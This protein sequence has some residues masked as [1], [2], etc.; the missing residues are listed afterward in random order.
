MNM[1]ISLKKIA[2]FLLAVLMLLAA[3]ACS[4]EAPKKKKKKV[5]K[6][7]VIIVTEPE[8]EINNGYD[9]EDNTSDYEETPA[10]RP[11]R[12]L[13]DVAVS[14]DEY[15]E[16]V[17][18]E[19]DYDYT[20]LNLS[21]DYVIVYGL[22]TWQKRYEGKD[23][24]ANGTPIAVTHT[25]NNRV[26]ANDLAKFFKDKYNLNL[27]VVLDTDPA[28]TAATKKILVGDTAFY[29]TNLSDKNFAVKVSGDNLIFEGGHF[30][31]VEKAVKWY[32]TIEV[33][34]GKVATLTGK[35]TDFSSSVTLSNGIKYDYVWGDEHDG[36]EVI[37]SDKWSQVV[38]KSGDDL[39]NVFDDTH[40][41]AV[42]NGRLRL[43]GDR[44]YDESNPNVGWA[45]SGETDTST[46][47]LFRNGYAE[48]RARL[49]Y[50]RGAFPAI[51]TMSASTA[52]DQNVPNYE[53]DDGYGVYKN[54]VWDIEFDLFESFADHDHM[55]T[56]V[57]KWYTKIEDYKDNG[58][59][60]QT[61]KIWLDWGDGTKFDVFDSLKLPNYNLGSS[62]YTIAYS[63]ASDDKYNWT[64]YFE[65]IDTLNNE[66]H[67]YGYLY[68]SDHVEVYVDGEMFLEFDWNPA[69]DYKNN[70]DVSKN[71]NGVGFNLWHYFIYDMMLYT[72]QKYPDR[73][74]DGTG[75]TIEDV[76]VSM[77]VDYVRLYQD[78]DD[79]S[80]ALCYPAAQQ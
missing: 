37:D 45:M 59:G 61:A 29:K 52:F 69:Y 26:A 13:P 41:H 73:Q 24:G 51:W 11:E 80:M 9:F 71:N 56:T 49:P 8:E 62:L 19:F 38:H 22:D 66:Y 70:V 78:L 27:K 77:Y 68:T 40:F 21:S 15:V 48:F 16:P 75:L 47:M 39:A 54:R 33:K 67:T 60:T 46:T 25:A 64:H 57:H 5:V 30:A 28:A 42:E 34:Q 31:M 10:R 74:L 7:K 79:P 72:P 2:C 76:P 36:N 20:E 35:K 23:G 12:P 53:V 43:T 18:P 3:V 1:S 50:A 4:E 44:Y 14:E 65:N 17:V 32:Q 63:A 58:D 55:T 6:K